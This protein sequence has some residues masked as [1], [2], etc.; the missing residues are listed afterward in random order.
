MQLT[1]H[2][3]PTW[4]SPLS[5]RGR[6]MTDDLPTVFDTSPGRDDP[7]A[8][9]LS[10][11]CHSAFADPR[12]LPWCRKGA[13]ADRRGNSLAPGVARSVCPWPERPWRC[14]RLGVQLC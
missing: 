9:S 5:S 12:A 11:L 6:R 13:V 7:T 3:G 1:E 10:Q 2:L 4:M 8:D 14:P